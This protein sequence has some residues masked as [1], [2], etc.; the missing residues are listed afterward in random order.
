MDLHRLAVSTLVLTL[1]LPG[2]IG[3]D[4]ADDP[5]PTSTDAPPVDEVLGPV[6]DTLDGSIQLGV[7]VPSRTINFGGAFAFPL[8]RS[9]NDTGYVLEVVWTPASP[10]GEEL[11]VWVRAPGV[12]DITPENAPNLVMAAPPL[13]SATGA[14]VLRLALAST[15]FPDDA[16]YEI[17]VR[18]PSNGPA[19]VVVEQPFEL[20][21]TTF[22]DVAFDP[23]Y[24]AAA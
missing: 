20:L 12:G 15:D 23:A 19:S 6:T 10:L 18:A 9:G 16:D 4:G 13:A 24:S 1:V 14:S 2:C 8:E 7:M 3:N 17:L 21:V 11:D 5:A 22:T